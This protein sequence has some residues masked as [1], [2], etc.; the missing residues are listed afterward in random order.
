MLYMQHELNALADQAARLCLGAQVRRIT[1][2]LTLAFDRHLGQAGLTL[3]Q[4]NVL[5][6][7][8][9]LEDQATAAEIARQLDADR[10]TLSREL[11]LLEE[12]GLIET[13]LVTG[14]RRLLQLSQAG[15]QLYAEAWAHWQRASEEM[16]AIYGAERVMRM[17]QLIREFLAAP[18][19]S[20]ESAADLTPL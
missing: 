12:R 7:I 11:G 3:S 19:R 8:L 1:R 4:F 17:Q 2:R 5:S 6:A 10:S 20:G 14:R 18:E 13:R 15:E 16:D 9:L